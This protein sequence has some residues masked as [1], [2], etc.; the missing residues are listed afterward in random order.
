[1]PCIVNPF[2]AR[3]SEYLSLVVSKI[4]PSLNQ[5]T[6]S[7]VLPIVLHVN[8]ALLLSFPSFPAKIN[9]IT[10]TNRA[11]FTVTVVCARSDSEEK[12]DGYHPRRRHYSRGEFPAAECRFIA[13][14][15]EAA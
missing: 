13:G 10:K 5:S 14:W 12:K 6:C 4:A 2:C 9:D 1:M 15:P 7:L 3:L 11:K 8:C